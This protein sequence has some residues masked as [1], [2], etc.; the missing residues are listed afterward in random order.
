MDMKQIA[1]IGGG[2]FFPVRNHFDL[3]AKGFGTTARRLADICAH[4]FPTM[5]TELYLTRMAGGCDW[6]R[7]NPDGFKLETNNDI[8]KLVE[9]LT[10]RDQ[11]KIVFFTAAMC[12]WEG[13]VFDNDGL[14]RSSSD[15][16]SLINELASLRQSTEVDV[17]RL[18]FLLDE[19][20]FARQ[21]TPSGKNQPRLATADGKRKLGLV[22]AEK[23]IKNVRRKRKDIY[24]VG[25]KQT[26][27]FTADQ[28]YIAALNLCKASSCNLVLANDDVTR[29]NMVVTPEEARYHVTND[30][31]EALNGLV[32][33]AWLRSHL[34]FTQSTPVDGTPIP[35]TS[36]LIPDSLR[37]VL[38]F[39]IAQG[40]Y[41]AFR[42]S[43]AGHFAVK[44]D[45]QT[46]LTSI[47][48]TD[49]NDIAKNGLVKI[50]TDGPDTVLAFGAKPSVGGQS[51]RIVFK[52]H[53][54]LD[55]IV[56]F[57]CPIKTGSLVPQVSQYEFECGSH[58]CG[59]NTS[60]GLKQF[61]NLWAVYLQEHGPNIV[62][63]HSIDPQEVIEFIKAN[64]D[65]SQKTGGFV[66]AFQTN[67]VRD[68]HKI[69]E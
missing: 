55:C 58:E 44:L 54:G 13:Y 59:K 26:S 28:Q 27:G 61:G 7:Y 24:L 37:T 45:D 12:D 35:W 48:K 4:K 60:L 39:C 64:F 46:F 14:L 9:Y 34:T 16:L 11:T 65:L 21:S 67:V 50:Q 68:A 36:P 40:A 33:M 18:R 53:P 49:F 69:L 23:V 32:N 41:K 6:T 10:S 43:T 52:D 17:N 63:N 8:A 47:R 5:D 20:E 57:H 51:Q 56:H 1:I 2:T 31:H 38:E 22:P 30:R 15:V 42:G 66:S 25:F 19:I 29:L 62:F 3:C